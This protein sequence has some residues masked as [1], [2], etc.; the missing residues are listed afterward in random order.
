MVT[1]KPIVLVAGNFIEGAQ[2]GISFG[3]WQMDGANA[4]EGFSPDDLKA[5]AIEAGTYTQ[6]E[7]AITDDVVRGVRYF[8]DSPFGD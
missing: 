8:G 3:G 4:D 2:G 1:L 7:E 5:M 6:V